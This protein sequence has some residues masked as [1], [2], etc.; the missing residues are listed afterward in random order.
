MLLGRTLGGEELWVTYLD[1]SHK[2]KKNINAYFLTKMPSLYDT[3]LQIILVKPL[4]CH[5]WSR[6]VLE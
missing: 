4:V 1:A 2:Q 6:I 3:V 5:R